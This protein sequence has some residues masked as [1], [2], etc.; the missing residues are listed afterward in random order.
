MY[1]EIFIYKKIVKKS[2]FLGISHCLLICHIATCTAN[3]TTHENDDNDKNW[4]TEC[5]C[6]K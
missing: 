6:I 1:D 3:I 4:G 2:I 5:N